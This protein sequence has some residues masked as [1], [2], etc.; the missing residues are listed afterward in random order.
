MEGGGLL[1]M[2]GMLVLLPLVLLRDLF[3]LGRGVGRLARNRR[4]V[5]LPQKN[6]TRATFGGFVVALSIGFA[7]TG[8]PFRDPVAA[9]A[10]A[11][12]GGLGLLYLVA[13]VFGSQGARFDVIS[14]FWWGVGALGCGAALLHFEGMV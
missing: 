7:A 11:G 2:C 13:G 4:A 12:V 3:R 14:V 1:T 6:M 5:P 9:W 8:I 10:L